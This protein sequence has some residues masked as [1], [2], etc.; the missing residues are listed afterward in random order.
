M[1]GQG[2]FRRLLVL[3]LICQLLLVVKGFVIEPYSLVIERPVFALHGL[4]RTDDGLPLRIVQ[5]SDLHCEAHG[6]VVPGVVEAVAAE[7]PDLIVLTGDYLNRWEGAE[8]L[9]RLARALRA[10][11]PVHAIRGNF[12]RH[13]LSTELLEEA[14]VELLDGRARRLEIRGCRFELHGVSLWSRSMLPELSAGRHKGLPAILLGHVPDLIDGASPLGYDLVLCGHTHGGQIRIPGYGALFTLTGLGKRY[15]AGRYRVGTTD[16]WVS[17]GLGLEPFPPAP[18]VRLF[19]PPELTV[20]T[21]VNA[22]PDPE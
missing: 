22:P 5:L 13:P 14:G 4:G 9:G 2:W 15:E 1:T 12:D 7:K 10:L 17:R 20:H 6:L 8:A 3:S 18:P 11:A 19:C 16:A 21:L